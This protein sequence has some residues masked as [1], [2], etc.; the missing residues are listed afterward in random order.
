[1]PFSPSGSPPRQSLSYPGFD[2]LLRG[3]KLYLAFTSVTGSVA[4][5]GGAFM[6]VA[7]SSVAMAVVMAAM[8]VLWLASTVH[9]GLLAKTGPSSLPAIHRAGRNERAAA[10]QPAA[11]PV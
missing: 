3:S 4:L 2:G 9:H 7:G 1:L 8:G 11:G 10:R 5:A 6:L